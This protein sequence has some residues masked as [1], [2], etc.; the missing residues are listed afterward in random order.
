MESLKKQLGQGFN[1]MNWK[2][3]KQKRGEGNNDNS[4]VG[5]FFSGALRHL[6]TFKAKSV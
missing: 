6:K 2:K 1:P 4:K 5:A 3:S